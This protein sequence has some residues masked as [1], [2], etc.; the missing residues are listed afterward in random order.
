MDQC[1]NRQASASAIYCSNSAS[2]A[3]IRM[4]ISTV[5]SMMTYKNCEEL[6]IL[7]SL[8]YIFLLLA[9]LV[10]ILTCL[11]W[12]IPVDNWLKDIFTWHPRVNLP[13]Q[14]GI[15]YSNNQSLSTFTTFQLLYAFLAPKLALSALATGR[16]WSSC[17]DGQVI[18]DQLTRIVEGK[19]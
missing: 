18:Q 16:W 1:F 3:L 12:L 15:I 2:T 14:L 13:S 9:D 11:L 5:L 6:S 17:F 10:R 7:S 19:Q 4:T 8:F